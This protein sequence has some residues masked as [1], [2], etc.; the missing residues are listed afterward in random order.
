MIYKK[1]NNKNSNNNN[2]YNNNNTWNFEKTDITPQFVLHILR[3]QLQGK[4][5]EKMRIFSIEKTATKCEGNADQ[6]RYYVQPGWK[7]SEYI[8]LRHATTCGS[9]WE[10][11]Q[12]LLETEMHK[13]AYFGAPLLTCSDSVSSWT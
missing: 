4:A 12:V 2:L 13:R 7:K 9:R 5:K 3:N 6:W 11:I 1:N 8:C 10:R